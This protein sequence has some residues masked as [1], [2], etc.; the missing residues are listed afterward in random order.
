MEIGDSL[1]RQGVQLRSLLGATE[2]SAISTLKAREPSDWAW[3]EFTDRVRIK[4]A[5][6]EGYEPGTCEMQILVS[7]IH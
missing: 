7:N 1:V 3:F 6:Q 5:E 2:F 4:W